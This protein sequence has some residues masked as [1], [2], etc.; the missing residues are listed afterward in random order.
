MNRLA[1]LGGL[2]LI[3]TGCVPE[4]PGTR[5]AEP[6][7]FEWSGTVLDRNGAPI[8][9]A[10]VGIDDLQLS[11]GD[12]G[13]YSVLS[14]RGPS[15][16]VDLTNQPGSVRSLLDCETEHSIGG[17]SS[18]ETVSAIAIEVDGYTNR[19]A[20]QGGLTVVVDDGTG[21]TNTWSWSLGPWY[22]NDDQENL[23]EFSVPTAS[24]WSFSVGELGAVGFISWVDVEGGSVGPGVVV[25][26]EATLEELVDPQLL[27]WDGEAAAGVVDVSLSLV[28]RGDNPSARA[29]IFEGTP[30]GGPRSL[31][32]PPG[33]WTWIQAQQT[34]FDVGGCDQAYMNAWIE[35]GDDVLALPP[36]GAPPRLSPDDETWANPGVTWSNVGDSAS[37]SV[38]G[39]FPS[40]NDYASWYL[41]VDPACAPNR[42]AWPEALPDPAGA[43]MT[44]WLSGYNDDS[45]GSCRVDWTVPN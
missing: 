41:T 8:A 21:S 1:A 38:W 42:A 3:G 14:E 5:G 23:I 4:A 25:D 16:Q 13:R 39:A 17:G 19:D 22:W 6:E 45:Y 28:G 31:S 18:L 37:L 2:V 24:S 32:M 33:D 30:P 11:T 36:P 7:L 44:G 10:P 26:G 29:R 27:E 40:V 35:A 34:S 15:R 20:L 9:D 43:S 12:D